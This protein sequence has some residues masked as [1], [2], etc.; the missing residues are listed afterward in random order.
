MEVSGTEKT[1]PLPLA[2]LKEVGTFLTVRRAVPT[3][4]VGREAG[5]EEVSEA[6]LRLVLGLRTRFVEQM[7]QT[8]RDKCRACGIGIVRAGAITGDDQ[9]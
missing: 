7:T 1:S 3:L 6:G 8:W 9:E 5:L 4:Q 2:M